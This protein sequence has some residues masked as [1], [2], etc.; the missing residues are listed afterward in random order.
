MLP[1]NKNG[2]EFYAFGVFQGFPELRHGV[3]TR[4]GPGG[5]DFSLSYEASG[6]SDVNRNID[7]AMGALGLPGSPAFLSQAHGDGI[8]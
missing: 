1:L 3:F 6:V 5:G 2:L 4:F 7:L 8:L